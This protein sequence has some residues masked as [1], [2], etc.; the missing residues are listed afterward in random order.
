MDTELTYTMLIKQVLSEYVAY[1]KQGGLTT[2]RLLF[3]DDEQ[4]YLVLNI[5][6]RDDRY[7]HNILVHIDLIDQQIWI[8]KDDTER[9]IA[10][11][12]VEAG[13]PKSDIVLGFRHPDVRQYTDFAIGHQVGIAV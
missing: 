11:A 9:G 10:T 8:Q 5:G 13:V 1:F 4:T 2:L 12:L 3:N 7:Q 6:W